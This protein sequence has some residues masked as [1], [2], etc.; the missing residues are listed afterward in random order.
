[1][2]S[3][4]YFT[5]L[6]SVFVGRYNLSMFIWRSLPKLKCIRS[7]RRREREIE[8]KKSYT[9]NMHKRIC[10]LSDFPFFLNKEYT[11]FSIEWKSAHCS[12]HFLRW[13]AQNTYENKNKK[14][15]KK[16]KKRLPDSYCPEMT[17]KKKS[18]LV[19]FLSFWIYEIYFNLSN[20]SS[21][22]VIILIIIVSS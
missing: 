2:P 19:I 6:L 14:I 7:I 1:M 17:W 18:I 13:F 10:I 8:R 21:F 11:Y 3:F 20:S 9:I 4:I 5:Y 16:K 22:I 15:K 12:F